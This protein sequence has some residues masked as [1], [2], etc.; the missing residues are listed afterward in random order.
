MKHWTLFLLLLAGPLASAQPLK[1]DSL[2][3]LAARASN[4]VKV[5][6]DGSLLHL[7]ARFLSND[8]P[9]EVQI[10][11]LVKGLKGI[12]VRNFEFSSLGQ[13]LDSDLDAVRRQLQD[14]SWKPIVEVHKNSD[15][16]NADVYVKDLG[17]RFG[18][19]AIVVAEPRELTVVHIDGVIDLDGLA[20][21]SGNFG[22]PD[23][24]KNKIDK[25]DK[26]GKKQK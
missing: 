4:T 5:T 11:Q 12:Y 23:N 6:L 26:N 8:D 25:L 10:K 2:D 9:D 19:V 24:V 17:D 22:I 14:A 20:K 21:L 15:G 1:L 18:G 3:K 7:A 13:Y 16:E